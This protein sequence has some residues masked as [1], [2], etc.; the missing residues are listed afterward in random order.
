MDGEADRFG[1]VQFYAAL[2]KAFVTMCAV[3]PVLFAI[4]L[5]DVLSGHELDLAGGIRPRSLPGLDGVIFAPFLHA[6][7]THL[8]S[9]SMPLL[10][11]GTF[12]LAT[13][14]RRFLW[15]T[16]LVVLVSGLGTWFIGPA[17]T[18]GVGASGVIFGYLGFLLVQGIVERSWWSVAV[19]VLMGILLGWALRGV[20]PSDP[21][22]SWQAHLFGLIGGVAA[23][24]VFR[25]RRP[26]PAPAVPPGDLF[27][28][29]GD[30]TGLGGPTPKLPD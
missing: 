23:A 17:G 8:S 6:S 27:G 15:V 26:K 5:I 29:L 3:I 19:S 2:G 11:T 10:I 13:G 9:N 16:A 18:V 12:V 22:I 14:A 7:F 24:V 25:R 20:L 4:E 30:S 28:G 1:T 21:H